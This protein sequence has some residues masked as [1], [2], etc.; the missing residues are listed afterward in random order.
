MKK[1][2]N[3]ILLICFFVFFPLLLVIEPYHIRWKCNPTDQNQE[4]LEKALRFGLTFILVLIVC[5]CFVFYQFGR[6]PIHVIGTFY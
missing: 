4:K 6:Y 3:L 5:I 1:K 2:Y